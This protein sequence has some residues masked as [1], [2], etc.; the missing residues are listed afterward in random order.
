MN[1]LIF[2]YTF[3]KPIDLDNVKMNENIQLYSNIYHT[4]FISRAKRGP[5]LVL[6]KLLL[7]QETRA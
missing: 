7:M 4:K 5:T 1:V 2:F 6:D 3:L